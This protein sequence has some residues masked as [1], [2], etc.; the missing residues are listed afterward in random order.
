MNQGVLSYLEPANNPLEVEVGMKLVM[1]MDPMVHYKNYFQQ[2][3]SFDLERVSKVGANKNIS[4][5]PN[6][7]G[8]QLDQQ[9]VFFH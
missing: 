6:Y 4:I 8:F 3:D 5:S 7:R 2:K 1:L 9:V